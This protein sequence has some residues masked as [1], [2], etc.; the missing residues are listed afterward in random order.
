MNT[1]NYSLIT[2]VEVSGSTLELVY[3]SQ[4]VTQY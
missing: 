2:K 1:E 4:P 3:I